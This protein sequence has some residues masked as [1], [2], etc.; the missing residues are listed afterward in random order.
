L[1]EIKE[2]LEHVSGRSRSAAGKPVQLLV[3]DGYNHS[4]IP[5]TLANPVNPLLGVLC[6]SLSRP[7][8]GGVARHAA[9]L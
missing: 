7:G 9:R 8:E 2:R 3:A 5:E 6:L 1:F 4:G